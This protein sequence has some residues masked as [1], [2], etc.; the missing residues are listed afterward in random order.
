MLPK[1]SRIFELTS[2]IS[3]GESK[4][5][6]EKFE[7]DGEWFEPRSG[8]H[9][10]TTIDGMNNLAK[11]R[12]IKKS[13]NKLRFVHYLDDYSISEITNNWVDTRRSSFGEEKL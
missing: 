2:L 9:W 12:R 4:T 11:L 1:G 10:K 5:G 7:F 13:G 6:G 3:S 8:Q